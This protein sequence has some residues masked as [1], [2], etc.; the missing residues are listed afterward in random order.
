LG[1]LAFSLTVF[2]GLLRGAGVESTLFSA[3]TS[4]VTFA[5]V[6]AAIGAWAGWVINDSVQTQLANELTA[7]E[8][9]KP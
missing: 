1:T 9:S 5:I 3:I 7:M 8:I 6:G 4:L 2:L